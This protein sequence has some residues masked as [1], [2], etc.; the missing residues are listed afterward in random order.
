MKPTCPAACP[1]K[2]KV[3]RQKIYNATNVEAL[4]MFEQ[5][6]PF[7]K[8]RAMAVLVYIYFRDKGFGK[9]STWIKILESKQVLY[10][11]WG[12]LERVDN[13]MTTGEW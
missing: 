10:F 3:E 2:Q 7:Y 4:E 11:V 8:R 6:S 5:M 9:L 1:L 12:F 13:A